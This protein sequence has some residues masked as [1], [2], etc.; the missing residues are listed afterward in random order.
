MP[1]IVLIPSG[2]VMLRLTTYHGALLIRPRSILG[3]FCALLVST[4]VA[5][6]NPW[7]KVPALSTSCYSAGDPFTDQIEA[8]FVANQD[9]IGRQEQINRGLNDQLKSIAPS[10]MQTRMMAYMQ[11]DPAGFHAYMKDMA[12]DPQSVQA[13]MAAD[14][15]RLAALNKEFATLIA[16]YSAE[17]K[18]TLDPVAAEMLRVTDAASTAPNAERAAAIAK[19]NAAYVAICNKWIVKQNF[20]A[21]FAKFKA[22]MV[23]NH[24]P[25]AESLGL[26]TK[27]SME[28]AGIN[29]K[30]YQSTERLQAV[31]KYIDYIRTVYSL[32]RRQPQG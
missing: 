27:R 11:K 31:S 8:A 14:N 15:A 1:T 16:N 2:D 25:V 30:D 3:L 26:V 32:R 21:F 29:T 9:A 19:Y 17:S 5:A 10:V 13:A 28:M 7:A 12:G 18:A 20:P 4:P 23:E 22:Y 24:V 6:Q